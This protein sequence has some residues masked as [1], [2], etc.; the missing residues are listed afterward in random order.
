MQ[1]GPYQDLHM[2]QPWGLP[3][4]MP[5]PWITQQCRGPSD[6]AAD[7]DRAT[8][9]ALIALLLE[10]G[11]RRPASAVGFIYGSGSCPHRKAIRARGG[12]SGFVAAHPELFALDAAM[13]GEKC[14]SI[15]L[16]TQAEQWA[17][18]Y[19]AKVSQAQAP[20]LA[21]ALQ[22]QPRK[23]PLCRYHQ[24]GQCRKGDDCWFEHSQTTAPHIVNVAQPVPEPA[25]PSQGR[26]LSC[27]EAILRKQVLFYF[28]DEN[29]RTDRYFQN[30]IA[31]SEGGWISMESILACKR[32]QQMGASTREVMGAL[33]GSQEVVLREPPDGEEA[34]KLTRAPPPLHAQRQ[35][36]YVPAE[37]PRSTQLFV[38]EASLEEQPL[39][40]LRDCGSGWEATIEDNARRS[41]CF[42]RKSTWP[43]DVL[44]AE[45]KLLRENV[46]W[47]GLKSKRE[48]L[49]R[50]TA[51]FVAA[52]CRCRYVYG[53]NSIEA[54]ERPEW[55]D[56][57][58]ARVLGEGCGLLREEWPDSVNLNLYEH[59]GQN[60]GWHSDDEGLFRGSDNDCRII[61]ASWG[62]PRVF[63]VALKDMD[64]Y[65]GRPSVHLNTLR[66]ISLSSGDLCSMEGLFQRHYSHQLA[67]GPKGTDA[68]ADSPAPPNVR[69]NLT[70][71][72]IVQHKPYCPL[73]YS[74]S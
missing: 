40:L 50:S 26:I 2:F 23:G 44:D 33:R 69:V 5:Q 20:A 21:L 31:Q 17:W 66:S 24:L 57:I 14:P 36:A 55:L 34:V 62:A 49:T 47:Q 6:A 8:T 11:G 59:D 64:H 35:Q 19:N 67:K 29:M 61:S 43:D 32:M 73:A 54:Q 3:T 39:K 12:V 37:P 52:G 38:P 15:R 56:S 58:E 28:S 25:A 27:R 45:Q 7:D 10:Y 70:W 18:L 65:S 13:P 51:W 41:W 1:H 60:V 53:D 9:L 74:K 4:M 48:V 22:P 16:R 72:Y 46:E 42:L 71:R 30:I 63:E 68:H